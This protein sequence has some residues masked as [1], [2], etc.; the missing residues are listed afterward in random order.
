MD[1][2]DIL[3]GFAFGGAAWVVGPFALSGCGPS[4][5]G[6]GS[7]DSKTLRVITQQNM[8]SVDPIWTTAPGTR[9]LG[10]MVYDQLI[11]VDANYQPR[12]QMVEGWTVEDDG[13]SYVFSLRKG[14][15]FHDGSPVRS[16]DCIASIAR[17]GARDN[18][19]QMLMKFV[20][21]QEAIDDR[22]FRIRLTQPVDLLPAAL[23]KSSAPACLIMP[24]RL[25]KTDPATQVT[26]VI[27][28]GPF[29][30]VKEEWIPGTGAVFARF[31]DYVPRKEPQSGLAG[32]RM[33]GVDRVV[34]TQLTD[35][36]TAMAALVA[37]EQDI[38]DLPPHDLLPL[39]GQNP[40]IKVEQRISS[41]A[42]YMLQFNHLQ[43]PFN[44]LAVRKAVAMAVNQ[45]DFMGAVSDKEMIRPNFSYYSGESPY[46][47]DAGSEIMRKPDIAAA[48]QAL[49]ASGYAGEKVVLLAPMEG[50]IAG[51]GQVAESL[52]K[53]IGL[54][55]EF[56]GLDFASM[57]QRRSNR[58]PVDKGGWSAFITA[59]LG[60]DIA[61]PAV[62]P[63]LRGAGE[64][65]YSGWA[66]DPEIERLRLEWLTAPDGDK[67]KTI[68]T[69]IQVQ[70]FQTLPYVPLGSSET[71]SAYRKDLT[72]IGKTPVTAYWNVGKAG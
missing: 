34:L 3:K 54:N 53:Q 4:K 44:T 15:K 18:Y 24:E 21:K 72:G 5:S 23:G 10:Y 12:P 60:D 13:R 61:D 41:N 27:G 64:K 35:P 58:G 56:I 29:R 49:A 65:G 71:R 57:T 32:S 67:R 40:D 43:P 22:K 55:V 31:E 39:L 6:G 42:Y 9:L 46:A 16:P 14:L 25:A 19:G 17:W 48:K 7:G 36:A 20:D 69:E 45:Q 66:T 52:L 8:A 11:G 2:R 59:W 37:G 63:M 26:D 50:A 30:F 47:T 68:A 62:H 33:A 1:R 28:S 70:A 51:L 38:W